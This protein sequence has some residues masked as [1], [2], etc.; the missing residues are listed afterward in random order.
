NTTVSFSTEVLNEVFEM[1]AETYVLKD[2]KTK[3]KIVSNLTNRVFLCA[4]KRGLW[5][6]QNTVTLSVL[7][8]KPMSTNFII[9]GHK[10]VDGAF[11]DIRK[12]IK[13]EPMDVGGSSA[14]N[15]STNPKPKGKGKGKGKREADHGDSDHDE[16]SSA[17]REPDIISVDDDTDSAR[18]SSSSGDEASVS[19][20]SSCE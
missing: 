14:S 17:G 19:A 10:F 11:L 4:M 1:D 16:E 5:T 12:S 18:S 8:L 7:A 2:N 15:A 13:Q 6:Q 9:S 20:S 3:R